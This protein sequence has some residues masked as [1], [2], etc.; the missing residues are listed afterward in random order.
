MY[1]ALSLI[2]K[3]KKEEKRL[4]N[5][6]KI[7]GAS[8]IPLKIMAYRFFFKFY[9]AHAYNFSYFRVRCRRIVSSRPA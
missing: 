8:I 4:K 1:E 3:Y 9:V 5:I 6:S 7:K 2:P